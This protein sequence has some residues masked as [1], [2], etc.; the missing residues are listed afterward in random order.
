MSR[1]SHVGEGK[2]EHSGINSMSEWTIQKNS[3]NI[4]TDPLFIYV[5]S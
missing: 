4:D 5:I 3:F 2:E 1:I